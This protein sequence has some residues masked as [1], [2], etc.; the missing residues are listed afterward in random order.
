VAAVVQARNAA[1]A[2]WLWRRHAQNTPWA[3]NRIRLDGW[4]GAEPCGTPVS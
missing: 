2:A 3:M 4:P 1:L